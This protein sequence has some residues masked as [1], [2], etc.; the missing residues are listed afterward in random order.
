MAL[1][2]LSS[3]RAVME[4]HLDWL[5]SLPG[6]WGVGI[7]RSQRQARKAK[8]ETKGGHAIRVLAH[9]RP[10]PDKRTP[11]FS[12]PSELPNEDDSL[13]VSVEVEAITE[14]PSLLQYTGLHRPVQ[15]GWSVG[16]E[17]WFTGTIGLIVKRA[18]HTLFP[19]LRPPAFPALP[20]PPIALP[21]WIVP[22]IVW[23]PFLRQPDSGERFA[24]SNMHVL[25]GINIGQV[26]DPIFQPGPLDQQPSAATKIGTLADFVPFQP[27]ANDYDCA[28]ARLDNPSNVDPSI[29]QIGRPTRTGD[30][31]LE[32]EVEKTGRT[33]G[34]TVGYVYLKHVSF[35]ITTGVG[36]G[37]FFR[38]MDLLRIDHWPGDSGSAVCTR[39]GGAI[40]VVGLLFAGVRYTSFA[41]ACPIR[42]IM[43]RLGIGLA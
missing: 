38:D 25:G 28:I 33:T 17:Y 20:L 40:T 39:I 8:G 43:Q 22:H 36:R 37:I 42:R 41:F 6:V 15:P 26:G 31:T 30:A 19:P 10:R 4:L 35:P 11:H 12:I 23:P 7:G 5:H 32:T 24:L 13:R 3:A 29:P 34:H 9:S 27:S 16:R 21:P 18:A 1:T 14:G 2:D